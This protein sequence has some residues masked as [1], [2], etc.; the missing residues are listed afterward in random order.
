[1]EVVSL[2]VVFSCQKG[3]GSLAYMPLGRF[4]LPAHAGVGPTPDEMKASRH[5]LFVIQKADDTLEAIQL[6][7]MGCVTL[8]PSEEGTVLSRFLLTQ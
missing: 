7:Q 2:G 5:Q 1:M 4:Y 8:P 6:L 3:L